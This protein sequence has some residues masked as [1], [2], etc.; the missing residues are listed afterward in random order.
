M[1]PHNQYGAE[2][3]K[4]L[5]DKSALCF[6]FL[7]SAKYASNWW[8][9]SQNFFC[10]P[11]AIRGLS[12]FATIVAMSLSAADVKRMRVQE[13]CDELGNRGLN[14]DGNKSVLSRRLLASLADPN[15][16][17]LAP[18][19]APA[20]STSQS[21]A[22]ATDAASLR[23]I[24]QQ[25]VQAAVSAAVTDAVGSALLQPSS[26]PPASV[27]QPA[28]TQATLAVSP[29]AGSQSTSAVSQ[30][31]AAQ[32][33]LAV[34]QPAAT[35]ASLANPLTPAQLCPTP[36]NLSVPMAIQDRILRGE[37]ID[38]DQLLPE[39]LAHLSLV[40]LLMVP[41]LMTFEQML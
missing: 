23:T 19:A 5:L 21:V 22:S 6:V 2:V 16:D 8:S 15:R 26:A 20:S 13:L 18:T 25:E 4:H 30:P 14:S 39:V 12:S 34:L 27:S 17:N 24:I 3:R 31:A 36:P 7:P 1:A 11:V 28:A 10:E 38:F 35:Q 9:W 29:P 37:Y 33:P 32:A 40:A 41:N